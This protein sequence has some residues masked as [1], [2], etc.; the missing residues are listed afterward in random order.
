MKR[1]AI[2]LA[3]VIASCSDPICGCTPI[4]G[5]A[6]AVVDGTVLDAQA[7]AV[8]GA[9]VS[10]VGALG[11]ECATDGDPGWRG[12]TASISRSRR[13]R[14]L[15]RIRCVTWQSRSSGTTCLRIP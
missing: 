13:R 7:M 3:F 8:A 5:A 6:W 15:S 14:S 11:V 9:E 4:G 1:V 2:V 10:P 12:C